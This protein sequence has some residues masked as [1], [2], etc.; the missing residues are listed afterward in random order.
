MICHDSELAW[1][2]EAHQIIKNQSHSTYST[3][4]FEKHHFSQHYKI[5]ITLPEEQL[6][7]H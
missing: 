2:S 1:K 6:W 3:N 5:K 4:F 7:K